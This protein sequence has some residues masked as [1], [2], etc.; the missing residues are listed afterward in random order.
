VSHYHLLKHGCLNPDR[1]GKSGPIASVLQDAERHEEH[2]DS[3]VLAVFATA[4][5]PSRPHVV[6]HEAVNTHYYLIGSKVGHGQYAAAADALAEQVENGVR[7]VLL[8]IARRQWVSLM[9]SAFAESVRV[10]FLQL[11]RAS[12]PSNPSSRI[13][14]EVR[15]G[16]LGKR[17]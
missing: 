4:N 15:E 1:V 13:P 10:A 17:G 8:P 12:R 11:R 2:V 16:A 6:A 7:R 9:A 3:S 14:C 5:V